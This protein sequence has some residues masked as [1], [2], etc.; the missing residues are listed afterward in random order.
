MAVATS[1]HFRR[2]C[3]TR[4]H[5]S[6]GLIALLHSHS[7]LR[8]SKR[9]GGSV[10]C[11]AVRVSSLGQVTTVPIALPPQVE[12]WTDA[13]WVGCD[14]MSYLEDGSIS[15]CRNVVL[16]L[17]FRRT[18]KAQKRSNP[19][20][21]TASSGSFRVA[22]WLPA[23]RLFYAFQLSFRV[24]AMKAYKR[25]RVYL[26]SFLTSALDGAICQIDT[27]T[28]SRWV[29]EPVS[30]FGWREKPLMPAGIRTRTFQSVG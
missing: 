28:P 19:K 18:D 15:S 4:S 23:P 22:L 17:R 14:G 20:C 13:Y 3:V 24:H 2:V 9:E 12:G 21:N 25:S 6:I 1:S 29:P 26:H 16:F 11:G 10:R 7:P 8:A 27:Q 5:G 30:T